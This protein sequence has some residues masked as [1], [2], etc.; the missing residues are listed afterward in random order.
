MPHLRPPRAYR[1]RALMTYAPGNGYPDLA[2]IRG[3]IGVP[4]TVLPDEQLEPIAAAE[5]DGV[6]RNYEWV[7]QAPLMTV[8]PDWSALWQYSTSNVM[9]DP[10]SRHFRA[11]GSSGAA[12]QFAMSVTDNEGTDQRAGLAALT[13]GQQYTVRSTTSSTNWATYTIGGTV[14]LTTW[15]RLDVAPFEH[16]PDTTLPSGNDRMLFDFAAQHAMAASG[17]LPEK[18]YGVF[19]RSVARAV[20]ARGVPLGILAADAEYGTVRLSMRDSEITRMGGQY[21]KRVFA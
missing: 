20:A 19:I 11:D 8:D 15:F 18:L 7:G 12:T 1:T 17:T 16:G 13:A 14:D 2:T 10:G 9:A 6:D 4:A 5:Q 3:E 21:R